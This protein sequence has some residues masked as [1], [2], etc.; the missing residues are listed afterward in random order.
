[1]LPTYLKGTVPFRLRDPCHA[2]SRPRRYIKG[3]VPFRFPLMG[4]TRRD[5][6]VGGAAAVLL[7][8]VREAEAALPPAQLRALR[9][10]V[11]GA[12]YSPGGGGYDAARVVFNKRWDGIRPP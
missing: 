1:M 10:T 3:T 2:K 12:V 9:A 8:P 5:L 6:L 4:V 11:R 7:A